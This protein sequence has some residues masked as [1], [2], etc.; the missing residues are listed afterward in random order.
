MKVYISGAITG[1][2]NY[3]DNF[4]K[5]EEELKQRGL[6]V[7]NPARVLAEMPET[8]QY[9]TYMAMALVML[10]GC[11]AIYMLKGWKESKGANR[12]L[13]YALGKGKIIMEVV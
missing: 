4:A 1:V 9:E 10:D 12:E 8:T 2:D 5:V 13:G 3:I 7:V 6:E 11:D